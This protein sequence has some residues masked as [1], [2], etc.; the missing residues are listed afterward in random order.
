MQ[1]VGGGSG[2]PQPF[3]QVRTRKGAAGLLGEH[4]L[5]LSGSRLRL[6]RMERLPWPVGGVRLAGIMPDMKQ[7]PARLSPDGQQ[8]HDPL[9]RLRII[10]RAPAW[11]VNRLLQIDQNQCR[12][13][14]HVVVVRPSVCTPRNQSPLSSWDWRT[15]IPPSSV[16]VYS[17]RKT[18]H[19]RRSWP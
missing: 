2:G 16:P 14:A 9:F 6:E 7:R 10:A 1:N 13:A 19:K 15:S 3:R 12:G 4:Q 17:H 18:H 5:A 8:T 11:V